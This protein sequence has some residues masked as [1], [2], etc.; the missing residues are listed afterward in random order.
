MKKLLLT[1][2]SFY[3][4]VT[5]SFS[6]YFL[7]LRASQYGGV[8]NVG[9]NP[10]IAGDRHRFDM[11]L[12]GF[13]ATVGNNYVG[14]DPNVFLKKN[15]VNSNLDFQETYLR[16]RLNGKDKNAYV[17]TQIQG[18][19]SFMFTFG[20]KKENHKNALA[21]TWNINSVTNVDNLSQKLARISY[22]GAGFKA[23]SIDPFDY[24]RFREGDLSVQTMTWVDYGIT[25]S[26]EV[27][28]KGD[29]YVKVGGTLK[30]IQGIISGNAVLKNAEYRWQ[31]FDTLSI[32]NT[33][34]V[35]DVNSLAP[36]SK[37]YFEKDRG[38]DPIKYIQ[39][40]FK[41]L[42]G[43]FS[44]AGDLAAVYEWRPKRDK[45]LYKMDGK[46]WYDV[47]KSLYTLQAG[48]SMTDLG[49]V[50]FKRS[51]YSY[52]FNLNKQDW[53]V[54][55]FKANDGLQSI[56]DTIRLTPGF[57]VLQTKDQ[58]PTYT[59]WLPTRFNFWLDYNPV[60]FFGIH[61]LASVAP[62]MNPDRS[63]HHITTFTFTPHLDW[64][65]FGLY[66]PVSYDMLGNFNFGSTIRIGPLIV[67]TSDLLGLMGAKKF[68]Y[69]A[70]VHVA[71]KIPVLAHKH[72][73][74]DKDFVSNREDRCKKQKG[75][76]EARGCPDRDGDGIL[77]VEDKCPDVPG[78]RETQGCPDRDGDGVLDMNDDC[79]DEKGSAELKGCPD[80]DKDGIPDKD[81]DCPEL[82][83]PAALKGCP[84]RDGDGVADKDD[85]CI[86]VPGDKAHKGC[87]DSDGDGLF[88]NEDACPREAGPIE[89]KGCPYKDTDGDGV[90]DKDDDCP[91]T[92]GEKDNRGC[93]KLAKK[94]LEI[95]KYAF[96][97]LEFET[98]KDIIRPSSFISLNGLAKLLVDKPSY[99]LKI[100]GHTDSDGDDQSNL[101]LSQKRAEA[102][103]RYL[104]GRGVDGSKLET[105]GFGE[106][107]PLAD[108]KT[109]EGKQKNRRVEMKIVF[110]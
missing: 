64:T 27:Y 31:N 61:A 16:E 62:R 48:F 82:A 101:I 10:A 11:T 25:Y 49:R 81:D 8:T 39:D 33:S 68:M 100:E 47:G 28:N 6:Q 99:G 107:R 95:I 3:L 102:V 35:L 72:L 66:L 67:G 73:D 79:P 15:Y 57:Q 29:H 110:K 77:D 84:D 24:Q 51:E 89:N 63:V 106:T 30:F 37:E 71:L 40:A 9:F 96:D 87:P 20:K 104:I 53:Y 70:D 88:D 18:P 93:P 17:A 52:E 13:G 7:G 91:T 32:Y 78:P 5:T 74:R 1:V 105:E 23:D 38:N 43:G 90:L 4:F 59:M 56:G 65:Y 44:A 80:T 45:Y 92:F 41:L 58:K 76:W 69:N 14:V 86:D 19:L 12:I 98:G 50:R 97:N 54:K 108:N 94:E 46:E 85:D 109:K 34:G 60:H 2:C 83:G 75:T 36:T 21:L 103:K 22:W 55:D 26:R 42:D